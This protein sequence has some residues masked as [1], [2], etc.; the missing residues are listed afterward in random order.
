MTLFEKI[1]GMLYFY[2]FKIKD[3]FMFA[4]TMSDETQ[5]KRN[6]PKRSR[7]YHA[8]LDMDALLKGFD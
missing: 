1:T 8:Q 6:L 4:A 3:S 5:C 2:C 7:Y